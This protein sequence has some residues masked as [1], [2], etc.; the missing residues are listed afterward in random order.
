MVHTRPAA[1]V[2]RAL[3]G[4]AGPSKRVR[5]KSGGAAFARV[6]VHTEAQA[7]LREA[8]AFYGERAR[9]SGEDFLDAAER[10]TQWAATGPKLRTL[11]EGS[12]SIGRRPV[13]ARGAL[14]EVE[15]FLF[16]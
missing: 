3:R 13:R 14:T 8:V 5:E 1:E 9:R 6:E 12:L 11:L 10:A 4:T 15:L 7:E 2:W 16:C